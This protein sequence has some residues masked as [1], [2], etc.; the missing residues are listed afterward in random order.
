MPA[1]GG[2]LNLSWLQR[3]RRCRRRSGLISPDLPLPISVT[4]IWVPP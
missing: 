4:G 3:G 2:V 1:Q